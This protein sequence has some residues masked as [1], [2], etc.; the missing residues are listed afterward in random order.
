MKQNCNFV[1]SKSIKMKKFAIKEDGRI[2]QRRVFTTLEKANEELAKITNSTA[3]II[4]CWPFEIWFRSRDEK[5]FID[6]V[7]ERSKIE[8]AVQEAIQ[9]LTGAFAISNPEFG[10][11]A[12]YGEM[13]QEFKDKLQNL[14][15]C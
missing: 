13:T 4:E 1:E 12:R 14:K 5:D 11:V 8:D 10:V 6:F 7:S 3:E 9:H 2:N 15:Q